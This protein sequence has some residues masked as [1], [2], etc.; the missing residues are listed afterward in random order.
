MQNDKQEIFDEVKPLD[1]AVEEQEIIDLAGYQVTK[2]ELFRTRGNRL[3]PSGRTASNSIWLACAGSPTSR[4]S[5]WANGGGEKER[6]NRDMCCHIFAA[7]LF[8]LM[9]WDKQYRYKMLGK[10]AVYGS[11]VLFLFNL[12]DF[13]LFVT[14]GSKKRRSYLPEDWRDYFGIPVERHEEAYRI[15][16]ADG[17]VTTDNA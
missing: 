14:T 17:Y 2:A 10:P 6:R 15:D 8:D 9:L 16:L 12:S 11:E 7:K 5:S 3:S 4:I 1:E 13:E